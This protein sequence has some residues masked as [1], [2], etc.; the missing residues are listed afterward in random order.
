MKINQASHAVSL[1]LDHIATELP[2]KARIEDS[3]EAIREAS[4]AFESIFVN[5]LMK[6]MR[7]TLPEDGM[8][9]GGFAN[10]VFNGMLDQEYASIASRSGQLGLA[11][12]IAEQLGA[13]SSTNSAAAEAASSRIVEV[14]GEE[15]PAWAL[16]EIQEDPWTPSGGDKV[17]PN[18]QVTPGLSSPK[19]SEFRT[20]ATKGISQQKAVE[21]YQ[22]IGRN[23]SNIPAHSDASLASPVLQKKP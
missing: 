16:E 7:K 13:G 2:N 22:T 20:Q 6:S 23:A 9:N 8:L 3:P 21:A 15:I 4:K 10:G 14:D 11:D 17:D 19:T 5:E 18:G 12:I 1:G